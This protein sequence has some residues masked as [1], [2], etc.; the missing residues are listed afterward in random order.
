MQGRLETLLDLLIAVL[1]QRHGR[2]ASTEFI[3]RFELLMMDEPYCGQYLVRAF[4]GKHSDVFAFS[5][6]H[7]YFI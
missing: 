1:G 2:C 5:F 4:E 7:S 6:F 3:A